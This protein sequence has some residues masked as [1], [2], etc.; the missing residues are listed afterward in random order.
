MLATD[1]RRGYL[2]LMEM[3]EMNTNINELE[4]IIAVVVMSQSASCSGTEVG[5]C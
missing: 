3:G 4:A 2:E 1:R 5:T